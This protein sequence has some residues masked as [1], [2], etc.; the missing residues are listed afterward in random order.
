MNK[1]E[2]EMREKILSEIRDFNTLMGY[3]AVEVSQTSLNGRYGQDASIGMRN[4]LEVWNNDSA[5]RKSLRKQFD[6]IGSELEEF[7]KLFLLKE[8]KKVKEIK[9]S[10]KDKKSLER[11]KKDVEEKLPEYMKEE[12]ERGIKTAKIARK[13]LLSKTKNKN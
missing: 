13:T 2:K 7:K 8:N 1:K 6:E 12:E 3:V 9:M 5:K 10:K 4:A 11:Y